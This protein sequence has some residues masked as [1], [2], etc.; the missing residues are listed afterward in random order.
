[1]TEVHAG[2][3]VALDYE[4]LADHVRSLY[5]GTEDDPVPSD[6]HIEADVRDLVQSWMTGSADYLMNLADR[7]K[8]T[9][10]TVTVNISGA[11]VMNHHSSWP[12]LPSASR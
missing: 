4:R 12:G 11:P 5:A 2:I 3:M 9:I 10:T 7:G 8:D 1:M 6:E